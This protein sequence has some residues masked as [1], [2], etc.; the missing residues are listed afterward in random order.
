MPG[1]QGAA[2][3]RPLPWKPDDAGGAADL[4]GSGGRLACALACVVGDAPVMVPASALGLAC[5]VSCCSNVF[6]RPKA[7][8]REI[9]SASWV[10]TMSR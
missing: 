1:G 8:E 3:L 7:P 9:E 2:V 10:V 5:F 4:R 6:A